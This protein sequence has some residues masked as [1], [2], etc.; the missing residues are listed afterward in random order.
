MPHII[1]KGHAIPIAET[2]AERFRL[3]DGQTITR[4]QI[5]DITLANA[6]AHLG[7]MELENVIG[8]KPHQD[9]SRVREAIDLCRDKWS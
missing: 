6:Q 5:R 4:D 1:Y 9:T 3:V 2:V 7:L 8:K